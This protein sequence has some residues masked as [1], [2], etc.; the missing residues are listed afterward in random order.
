[1]LLQVY[2]HRF[3]AICLVI[4][5]LIP[6]FIYTFE[7]LVL[8]TSNVEDAHTVI[9]LCFVLIYCQAAMSTILLLYSQIQYKQLSW[10][11]ELLR[12]A[13]MGI[14]VVREMN[15]I[16]HV[17]T[18]TCLT[19][20]T[21]TLALIAQ[22]IHSCF[23]QHFDTAH[24]D[25]P[26]LYT[27]SSI[28]VYENICIAHIV[29]S[30]YVLLIW[31][32]HITLLATL[33]MIIVAEMITFNIDTSHDT[34]MY[35][36]PVMRHYGHVHYKLRCLL[37]HIDTQCGADVIISFTLLTS[38]VGLI[39]CVNV[40]TTLDIWNKQER[41]SF[42]ISALYALVFFIQIFVIICTTYIVHHFVS[43]K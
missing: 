14:G 18:A 26:S 29:S 3:V 38:S 6:L 30:I 2:F 19:C 35:Q 25:I 33:L 31:S 20:L 42:I 16:H 1:L 8:H 15:T 7:L 32:C 24:F 12:E 28:F 27:N 43:N 34:N 22:L 17:T 37:S 21:I 36:L 23:I 4:V 41:I 11:L 40:L 5:A 9:R 10:P 13:T 39:L